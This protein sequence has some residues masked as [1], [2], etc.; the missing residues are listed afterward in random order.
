MTALLAILP[1][2][3]APAAVAG[4]LATSFAASFLTAAFGIGGGV[5]LLAA[6]ASLMPAA[7]LIPVHGVVQVGSNV[8]RAVVLAAHVHRPPLAAFALGSLAGVALGGLVAVDLPP[9][10]IRIGVGGFVIWSVLAAA[11][12]WFAGNPVLCGAVS[13]FLTMFF[14]ATGVFVASFS[15]ALGLSRQGIV[16]T[17]AALMTLQH[18]LKV[19]MFGLLGFAYGPWLGFIALMILAGF[20]GT[21]LGR[22]LLE[23][24]SDQRFRRIFDIV[25]ILLAIRLIWSGVQ[26]LLAA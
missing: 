1:A 14:G 21:L 10:A 18:A 23:R 7:A 26:A 15:R 5:L 3:L 16:G 17:H 2:E 22:G 6:M 13:S 19:A 11:P 24:W 4:L 12:A 20:A 25:L 9:A 8:G